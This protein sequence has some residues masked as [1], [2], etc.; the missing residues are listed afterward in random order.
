VNYGRVFVPASQFYS[1]LK[2]WQAGSGKKVG[3]GI[4]GLGHVGIKIAK[5]W[6]QKSSFSPHL[7]PN[8]KMQ[9]VWVQMKQ[10]YHLM[11]SKM[12]KY[13][14]CLHFI[15]DTVSAKRD[16]NTYLNLLRHDG[17]MVLVGLP[18]EPLELK[19]SVL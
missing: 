4:G 14:R 2:H 12:S 7:L 18:P 17:S 10:Y 19:H 6:A 1:P 16:G 3:I 15:I 8:L 5:L 13:Y 9:N 11:K